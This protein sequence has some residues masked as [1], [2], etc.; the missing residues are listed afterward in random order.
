[1]GLFSG[2]STTKSTTTS[3]TG[4]SS[5]QAPYL[6]DV[7]NNAQSIY[8]SQA[9]TPYY[10]GETYAGMSDEAKQALT[11]LKD[12][13]STT[14]MT[15]ATN[16]SAIGANA[17]QNATA[18][19][20]AL[21]NLTSM[22]TAD[23]TQSNIASAS[24]YANNPYMDSM[25]DAASRD[26]TRNLSENTLPSIDRAAS[27]TGNI[28][29]SRAGIASGIAQRGAA[30][31]IADISA[32]LRG[33]A[34]SQGLSQASSDRNSSMSALGTAAGSYNSL[35][36]TGL[37]ALSQGNSTA[38]GNYD[39]I[40]TA[41]S[42]EQADRQGQDTANLTAWQNQDSRASD[43]LSRYNDIVGS[44]QWGSSGTSSSTSKQTSSA[45]LLSQLMGAASLAGGLYTGTSTKKAAG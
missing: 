29:S 30:D 15:N 22:A 34:Y 23:P 31:S 19:G 11:N 12:Y 9:G 10:Q 7:F 25:V 2:S 1:M 37:S 39:A 27:A 24:A 14:G 16:M 36:N 20:S 42:A 40:N 33:Q 28:N 41:N 38:L 45:S 13:A 26:V 35:A 44:S 17:S 32:N 8:N 5:F 3:D 6:T 4:P 18:A 43:L 21:G